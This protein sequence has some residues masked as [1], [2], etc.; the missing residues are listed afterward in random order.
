MG[1]DY[2]TD[3]LLPNFNFWARPVTFYPLASGGTDIS[4]YSNRGIYDSRA[5]EYLGDGGVVIQDQETILD[6]REEEFGT[7]PQQG[8]QV[9]IGPDNTGGILGPGRSDTP[10]QF[11]IIDRKSNGGGEFTLTLRKIETATP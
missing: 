6:I 1:V 7:V 9:Y 3:I 4:P 2:S 8:D 11:E 5:I 10:G